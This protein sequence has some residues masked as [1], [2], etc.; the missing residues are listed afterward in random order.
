MKQFIQTLK[1]MHAE[2]YARTMNDLF[3]RKV[4]CGFF[5]AFGSVQWKINNALALKRSGLNLQYICVIDDSYRAKIQSDTTPIVT[6]K[7]FAALQQKPQYMFYID[8]HWDT[9]FM[10]YFHRLGVNTFEL[11][12]VRHME[13]RYDTFYQHLGEI[14]EVYQLFD[15]AESRKTYRQALKTRVSSKLSDYHY[16]PEPQYFLEPFFPVDGDIAIDGGA[17]DGGTAIDFVGQGAKVYAFEMDQKNYQQILPRAKKHHFT[18]ENM[19][20]SSEESTAT[21]LSAGAGSHM[22]GGGGGGVTAHFIDIDTYVKRQNLPRIDYIKLDIEG[23]ELA[24]LKGAAKSIVRWKPKMAISAYHKLEDIWTLALYIKSLR[25]DYEFAFRHYCIDAR[26]YIMQE[27]E[28]NV[29]RQHDLSLSVP[30]AGE[31]VLYCK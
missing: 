20:L 13:L 31:M 29:L 26:D 22:L 6:L 4:P 5:D 2:R 12:D 11:A 1:E 30:T 27:S 25:A 16:A 7:E 9:A 17:F 21:Y 28:K 14:S 18:I 10:P 24:C 3:A 23:A 15:D 8:S 19:G